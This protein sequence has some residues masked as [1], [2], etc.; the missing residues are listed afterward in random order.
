MYKMIDTIFS[1]GQ[2]ILDD[3]RTTQAENLHKAAE[4]I[5]TAHK[6]GHKFFVSGSGHSHTVAEDRKSVV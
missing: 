2:R 4:L 1:T 5:A 3:L 6:N